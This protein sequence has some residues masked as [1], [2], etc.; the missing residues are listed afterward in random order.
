MITIH[1]RHRQTDRQTD[2]KR[3]HDRYIAKACSG[4]NWTIF[5]V[6]WFYGEFRYS[7]FW[8]FQGDGTILALPSLGAPMHE[9]IYVKCKWHLSVDKNQ[10]VLWTF[11]IKIIQ[12]LHCWMHSFKF[13]VRPDFLLVVQAPSW[14]AGEL[15]LFS[16]TGT[17]REC[18][19]KKGRGRK[20]NGAQAHPSSYL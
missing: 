11:E 15:T 18:N 1:Q 6:L 8:L 19:K 9:S 10:K 7:I 17:N 2:A 4:K 14:S 5:T 20:G 3:S 12:D 13:K 16:R